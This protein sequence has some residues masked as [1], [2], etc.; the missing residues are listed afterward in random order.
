M[1]NR[2]F[3]YT[4]KLIDL[5]GHLKAMRDSRK[6]PRIATGTVVHS[7]LAMMLCRLGSLNALEQTS[8]GRFWIRK[9]GEIR[10]RGDTPFISSLSTKSQCKALKSPS[11]QECHDGKW[12]DHIHFHATNREREG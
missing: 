4:R 11:V 1:L 8:R 9:R 12:P 5:P 10:K 2:I 6:R 7:V 3:G